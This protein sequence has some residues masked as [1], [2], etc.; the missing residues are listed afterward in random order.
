MSK[1]EDPKHC[2]VFGL[3]GSGMTTALERHADVEF[4][5]MPT[6]VDIFEDKDFYICPDCKKDVTKEPCVC[7]TPKPLKGEVISFE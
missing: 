3:T 4:K 1:K 6:I 5:G 7:E 2:T